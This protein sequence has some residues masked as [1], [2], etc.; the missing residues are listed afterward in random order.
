MTGGKAGACLSGLNLKICLMLTGPETNP[1]SVD[2]HSSK[3]EILP[4][5]CVEYKIGDELPNYLKIE[6]LD[7]VTEEVH[8]EV[9]KVT[10]P[11]KRVQV[12]SL[13][14]M[15]WEHVLMLLV[16]GLGRSALRML[17]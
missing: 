1:L 9:V 17:T 12:A 14:V 7:P 6:V 5:A 2:D 8:I 15:L 13:W 3:L 11:L 10:Y 16:V 4:F